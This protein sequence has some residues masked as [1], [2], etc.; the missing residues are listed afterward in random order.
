MPRWRG[1]AEKALFLQLI[2]DVAESLFRSEWRAMTRIA[3]DGEVAFRTDELHRRHVLRGADSVHLATALG[4]RDLA[5][6]AIT[7]ACADAA[8]CVAARAEGLAVAP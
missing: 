2:L 4:F 5:G 7:F 8:L 1:N 3:L 6:E